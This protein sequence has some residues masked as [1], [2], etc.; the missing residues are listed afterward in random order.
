MKVSLDSDQTA[1]AMQALDPAD[2]APWKIFFVEDITTGLCSG[3]P[4]LDQ[5]LIVRARQKTKGR[6]D[7]TIKFRP[8]AP[9]AAHR[10]VAGNDEV[11]RRG[12]RL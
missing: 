9:V 8:G 11:R 1:A 7:V 3:T 5:H 6:D 10:L 4:L 2:G 12:P